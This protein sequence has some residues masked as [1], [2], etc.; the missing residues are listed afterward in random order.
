MAL[1]KLGNGVG[2][3]Y[4]TDPNNVIISTI[5]NIPA[6]VRPI[7]S[8]ALISGPLSG[9]VL[10]SANISIT[11]AGDITN[12]T[13]D[14][15]GIM[16]ASTISGASPALLASNTV[17]AINSAISSPDY[18]ATLKGTQF[19]I[20]AATG[21]GANANGL[22][23]IVS[24]ASSGAGTNT[25]TM[26][27]G[28]GT[29]GLYGRG[30]N[31]RRFYINAA[32]N[33]PEGNISGATE[34]TNDII[35]QGL[36]KAQL[37]SSTTLVTGSISLPRVSSQ[38]QILIDTEGGTPTGTMTTISSATY[39]DGD[40]LLLRGE[41]SGHVVTIN[42]AG[43]IVLANGVLFLTGTAANILAVQY[44]ATANK[45]YEIFRSPNLNLATTALRQGG[46]PAMV[47]GTA[48]VTMPTSGTLTLDAATSNGIQVVTGSPNLVGG[49]NITAAGT[50]IDGD[51]WKVIYNAT[52]VTGGV[53]AVTIFGATL[54]DAQATSGKVYVQSVY[55]GSTTSYKTDVFSNFNGVD[56]ATAATTASKEPALGNPAANGYV[57]ASTTV[58]VRSWVPQTLPSGINVLAGG[59]P[60][61]VGTGANTTLTVL[62]TFTLLGG[63][64]ANNGDQIVI[65]AKGVFG[66]DG[67]DKK[68][69]FRIGSSSTAVVISSQNNINYYVTCT[70]T[71]SSAT[72]LY[73]T[74]KFFYDDGTSILSSGTA[75]TATLA[76][77]N[78]V[79][80]MGQNGTA[81][82][83]DVVCEFYNVN[84]YY[85][86]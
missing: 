4:I 8:E 30:A 29:G 24:Y 19:V 51:I 21:S 1:D 56:F 22:A 35:D 23:V 79:S 63:T 34:I 9:E 76:N 82:A 61:P 42:Q 37:I 54:T 49:Y 6:S 84:V 73:Y 67:N 31:G 41:N 77:N 52:P 27:G 11:H 13:V 78:A 75:L 86:Q 32:S 40:I 17:D 15:V 14:G 53:N 57:L 55:D 48:Q 39:E 10:A 33:A 2:F 70:M 16:G 5:N 62:K 68:L 28:S 58:G 12:I 65:E 18:T 26:T 69:S 25:A 44:N 71:R 81:V 72:T 47:P 74:M 7:L 46:I 45:W 36:Q 60:T 20:Q 64:L 3:L 38:A 83:N 66:A 85:K 43:N 59:D 50:P 80:I